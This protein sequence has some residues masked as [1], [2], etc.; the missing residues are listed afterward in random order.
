MDD[1]SITIND[2]PILMYDEN[3]IKAQEKID[4]EN[5]PKFFG[6]HVNVQVDAYLVMPDLGENRMKLKKMCLKIF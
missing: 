4:S 5:L 6:G 2:N 1:N 3:M